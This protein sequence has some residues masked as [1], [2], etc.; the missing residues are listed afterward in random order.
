MALEAGQPLGDIPNAPPELAKFASD[1]PPTEAALVMAFPAA[2]RAA[3]AASVAGDG[4]GSYWS[5]VLARLENLVTISNGSHVVVGAP[6]AGVIVQAQALLNAGD[7]A[8]AVAEVQTLSAS[9][10][11]AMGDW[12]S[13]AQDLLAARAAMIAMANGA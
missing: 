3:E 11:A 8:G 10:Q 4:K 1:P 12:L 6:A 7:L 2:A 13:Q 9:T 5:A